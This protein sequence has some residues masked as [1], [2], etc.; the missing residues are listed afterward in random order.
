M[1]GQ[2]D[3]RV[4]NFY[5]AARET[6]RSR[7]E[8]SR[9]R[10]RETLARMP[11]DGAGRLGPRRGRTRVSS[12]R[13]VLLVAAVV[14]ATGGVALGATDSGRTVATR[15]VDLL[16]GRSHESLSRDDQR[17]VEHVNSIS[18]DTWSLLASRGVTVASAE[19][20]EISATIS[21][22]PSTRDELCLGVS[23]RVANEET[24]DGQSLS[25]FVALD[26]DRPVGTAGIGDARFQVLGGMTLE[27][28]T[29]VDLLVNGSWVNVELKHGAFAWIAPFP[30]A[31]VAGIRATFADG[32]TAFVPRG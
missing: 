24:P 18:T 9:L 3:M 6:Q 23:V 11:L 31:S 27:S 32:T 29:S 26:K 12:K 25:C 20:G 7:V 14:L 8:A 10:C 15:A 2:L 13:S 16:L 28:V 30:T 21:A 17:L 19:S 4:D 22:V 5:R 1:T